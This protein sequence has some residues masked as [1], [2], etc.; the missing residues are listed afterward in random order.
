MMFLFIFYFPLFF[1]DEKISARLLSVWKVGFQ[2]SIR[3]SNTFKSD[4]R[5]CLAFNDDPNEGGPL[6][7]FLVC[8]SK[9]CCRLDVY[10]NIQSYIFFPRRS[11]KKQRRRKRKVKR[12]R[13][14]RDNKYARF[15]K[16]WHATKST[17][18]RP[19]FRLTRPVFSSKWPVLI[20]IARL[21]VTISLFSSL[22]PPGFWSAVLQYFVQTGL[23][24]NTP[25]LE[26]LNDIIQRTEL[27]KR[28]GFS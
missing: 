18:H 15:M 1:Y 7:L 5:Y 12:T 27:G 14:R 26:R 4:A 9:M 23:T 28:T 22:F 2:T 19:L 8:S 25:S 21:C 24:E 16:R 11:E 3:K 20:K 6:L 13:K 17:C 10:G